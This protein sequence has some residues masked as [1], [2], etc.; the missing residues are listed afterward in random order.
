[1]TITD[2]PSPIRASVTWEPMKPAP[3]VTT[4]VLVIGRP[5]V[6]DFAAAYSGPLKPDVSVEP[7]RHNL[8]GS[9][10]RAG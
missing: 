5:S 2:R 8:P 7:N 1:M 4:A 6:E 3:P 10:T 9:F